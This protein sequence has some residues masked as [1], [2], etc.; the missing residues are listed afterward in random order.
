M[1]IILPLQAYGYAP[2]QRVFQNIYLIWSIL[3]LLHCLVTRSFKFDRILIVLALF[4]LWACI[5]FLVQPK[6][7]GIIPAKHLLTLLTMSAVVFPL[8][9]YCDGKEFETLLKRIGKLIIVSTVMA[10]VLSILYYYLKPNIQLPPAISSLFIYSEGRLEGEYRYPGLFYH[11][12]M[13]GEKCF[14]SMI[15]SLYL[16][17]KKD[18]PVW[19]L[20]LTFVT[21][22]WMMALGEPRTNYVQIGI[23]IIYALFKIICQKAGIK[24]AVILFRE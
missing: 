18:I 14:L 4:F 23:V 24:R 12:V 2:A 5:T 6:A 21:S 9:K 19:G 1:Y 10:S 20:I 3:I 17:K 16:L 15:F 8:S 7:H 13:A 22:I 11:P